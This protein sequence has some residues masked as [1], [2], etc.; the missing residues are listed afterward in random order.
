MMTTVV[1][2]ASEPIGTIQ[3][4]SRCGK[5]LI[6]CEGAMSI[7][8]Q[9]MAYWNPGSY[10]GQTSHCTFMMSR[11]AAEFDESQCGAKIQ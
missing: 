2:I 7:D 8:G 11:D 6:D 1:H 9:G 3:K 5:F 4:C 10:I